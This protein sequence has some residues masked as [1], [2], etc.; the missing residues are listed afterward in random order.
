MCE[1][2][3]SVFG[4]GSPRPSTD[5]KWLYFSSSVS[6][7]LRFFTRWELTFHMPPHSKILASFFIT[8]PGGIL[9]N[10]NSKI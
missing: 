2:K 4:H 6:E 5:D 7:P 10:Y 8:P 9:N 3:L 1:N